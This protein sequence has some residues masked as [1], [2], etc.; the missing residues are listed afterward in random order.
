MYVTALNWLISWNQC[1]IISWECCPWFCIFCTEHFLLSNSH[2][3][4]VPLSLLISFICHICHQTSTVLRINVACHKQRHLFPLSDFIFY[5]FN[6]PN[7]ASK[8]HPLKY[9]LPLDFFCAFVRTKPSGQ[10]FLKQFFLQKHTHSWK[11]I[12][13]FN[14]N[15]LEESL[16]VAATSNRVSSFATENCFRKKLKTR[17]KRRHGTLSI[18]HRHTFDNRGSGRTLGRKGSSYCCPLCYCHCYHFLE[19]VQIVSVMVII[20]QATKG[21]LVRILSLRNQFSFLSMHDRS[22]VWIRT[23]TSKH[24]HTQHQHIIIRRPFDQ[25]DAWPNSHSTII[26]NS[27]NQRAWDSWK[28]K[29]PSP[30]REIEK[31]STQ[32]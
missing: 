30:S 8:K 28:H 1:I 23:Q 21:K 15:A 18:G 5:Q 2:F 20:T 9:H 6:A 24:V 31:E 16:E 4:I 27:R 10:Q 26:I 19:H 3:F 22:L 12:T 7:A 14:A 11:I 32:S 17:E 25:F 13:T 29:G